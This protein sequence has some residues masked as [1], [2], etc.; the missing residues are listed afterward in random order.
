MKRKW[1]RARAKVQQKLKQVGAE[2]MESGSDML[3][4]FINRLS[5]QYVERYERDAMSLYRAATQPGALGEATAAKY[6]GIGKGSTDAISKFGRA[7]K[8]IFGGVG[9]GEGA[10]MGAA[11]GRME[12][13]GFGH[14]AG[15][16][17]QKGLSKKI[18]HSLIVLTRRSMA[19]AGVL[20]RK[21][22]SV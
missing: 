14:I 11:R 15:A 13:A 18:K 2:I 16:K 10:M 5:D 6:F 19:V 20:I 8:Q 3:D 1:D 17:T 7:Q 22:L 21:G 4:R 9:G 12:E